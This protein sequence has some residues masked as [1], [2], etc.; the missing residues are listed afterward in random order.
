MAQ[1]TIASEWDYR[2][3]REVIRALLAR[4]ISSLELVERSIARIESLDQHL[5]AVI[6]RDFQ[7][8]REAARAADAALARGERRPLLD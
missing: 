8:A 2:A 1:K 3:T 5:N 4:K 6:V 7:R